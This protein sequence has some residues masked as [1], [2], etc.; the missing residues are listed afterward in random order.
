[1]YYRRH[2]SR[3][4]LEDIHR[5]RQSRGKGH[6]LTF[7]SLAGIA[8]FLAVTKALRPETPVQRPLIMIGA[9]AAGCLMMIFISG[10]IKRE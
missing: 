2:R 1:M 4:R 6:R 5:E 7:I 10:K 9:V 3:R 8:A